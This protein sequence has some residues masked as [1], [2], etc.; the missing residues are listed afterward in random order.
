MLRVSHVFARALH[1]DS[2]RS[3]RAGPTVRGPASL[4][5]LSVLAGCGDHTETVAPPPTTVSNIQHLVVV[6]QENISFDTYFAHYCTAPV[7]S[8]PS[9]TTGPACCETGPA[10]DPGTGTAPLLLNGE[11]HGVF[12]PNHTADCEVDEIDG[13]K[14]DRY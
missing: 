13:G 10:T 9:C 4:V 6:I 12:D 2:T 1:S 5:L 11:Q 3:G 7:G 14:M 8:Q